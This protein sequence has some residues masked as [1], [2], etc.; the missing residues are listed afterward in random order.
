MGNED[1]KEVVITFE[2]LYDA[3]RREK[4][5]DDLQAISCDFFKDVLV[6]LRE[7]QQAYDETLGKLDLFSSAEREKLGVQLQNIRKILKE[8]YDRRE[9]KVVD[10]AI[11]KS[12]TQSNIIDTSNM[13]DH[14]K[15]FYRMMTAIFDKFRSDVLIK[16]FELKEPII[17]HETSEQKN[18]QSPVDVEKKTKLVKFVQSTEQFVGKELELYGPFDANDQVYLPADIADILISKGSALEAEEE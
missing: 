2:T 3:L 11:N 7:K 6:Y 15:S 9:R 8:L 13:L 16:L 17:E 5:R 4:S 12:R 1:K 18:M 10:I 14:E